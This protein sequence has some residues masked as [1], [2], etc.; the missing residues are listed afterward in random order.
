MIAVVVSHIILAIASPNFDADGP[1]WVF[2]FAGFSLFFYATLDN[3]DGKQ[4]R[5]TGSSS[6]LGLLFDHGCDSIN[7]G[8][9][10]ATCFMACVGVR[11]RL[12][13]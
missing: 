4:A 10:S 3:M 7:A 6:A 8:L 12:P 1:R 5:R 9:L 13:G 2:P 11:C